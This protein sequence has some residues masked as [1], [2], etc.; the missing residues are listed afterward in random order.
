MACSF[1]RSGLYITFLALRK[2]SV[3]MKQQCGALETQAGFGSNQ[4]KHISVTG[5][6]PKI[7][8]H[9]HANVAR[10]KE[11]KSWNNTAILQ[12]RC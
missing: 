11:K 7:L 3:N 4:V 6:Q 5:P 9:K 8:T 1:T 2:T 10:A 12:Q